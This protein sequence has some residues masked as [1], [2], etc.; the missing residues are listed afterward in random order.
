MDIKRDKPLMAIIVPCFNEEKALE[1]ASLKLL[2]MFG[3]L[4]ED[5]LISNGRI[6]IKGLDPLGRMAGNFTKIETLFDLPQ[7]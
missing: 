5:D 1:A 7:E 4:I 3:K 2:K 6:D